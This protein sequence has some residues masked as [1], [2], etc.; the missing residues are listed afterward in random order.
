[1][2][3]KCGQLKKKFKAAAKNQIQGKQPRCWY[4]QFLN[5]KYSNSILFQTPASLHFGGGMVSLHSC[6]AIF[7]NRPEKM[8]NVHKKDEARGRQTRTISIHLG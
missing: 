1:M 6:P 4:F 3:E 8:D 2:N 5:S 7:S